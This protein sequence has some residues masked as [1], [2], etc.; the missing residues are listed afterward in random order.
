[1]KTEGFNNTHLKTAFPV[2]SYSSKSAF[3]DGGEASPHQLCAGASK[4]YVRLPRSA[5]VSQVTV[6]KE[7]H[8]AEL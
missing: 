2:N 5:V 7:N 4:W 3:G 6:N 8:L 1:M